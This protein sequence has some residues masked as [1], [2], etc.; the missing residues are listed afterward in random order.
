MPIDDRGFAALLR[1]LVEQVA[2]MPSVAGSAARIRV[3]VHP[4]RDDEVRGALGGWQGPPVDVH[5]DPQCA[6]DAMHVRPVWPP[7]PASEAPAWL[8]HAREAGKILGVDVIAHGPLKG[9]A[10][11]AGACPACG[12]ESLGLGAGGFVT[13]SSLSC[14]RPDAPSEALHA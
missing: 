12:V 4:D 2:T 9:C 7:T 10:R 13:C 8:I 6:L 5:P 11:V 1:E 14:P 3:D